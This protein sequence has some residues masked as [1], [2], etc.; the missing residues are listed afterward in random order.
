MQTDLPPAKLWDVDSV[1]GGWTIAQSRFF[2]AKKILDGIQV[3]LCSIFHCADSYLCESNVAVLLHG[4]V[5]CGGVL[6]FVPLL[7]SGI[8]RVSHTARL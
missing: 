4:M 3:R 1:F 6:S 2:D 8:G 5:V 7:S